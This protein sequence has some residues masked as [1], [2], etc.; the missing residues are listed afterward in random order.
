MTEDRSRALVP[1]VPGSISVVS[2]LAER[3]LAERA[4]RSE[5]PAIARRTLVVGSGGYAT[6]G[7]AVAL[8][9]DG[10]TVLVRPGTYR[11]QVIITRAITLM[12]DGDRGDIVIE[13]DASP[14]LIAERSA[15]RIANL[16]IRGTGQ[17]SHPPA[18]AILVNS[19][20]PSLDRL[21]LAGGHG[22]VIEGRASPAIRG[23]KIQDSLWNGVW[24]RDGAVVAIED[25][26]IA[27]AAGNVRMM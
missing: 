22:I 1:Q 26:D 14:C 18:A 16:T 6:V 15:A 13:F 2:R 9:L 10:D 23:C 27:G 25:N 7:E 21:V 11:E 8:A 24:V 20:S 12:G 4:A 3:T 17:H 19:G 5:T